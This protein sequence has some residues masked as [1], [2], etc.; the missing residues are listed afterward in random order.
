MVHEEVQKELLASIYERT[1]SLGYQLMVMNTFTDMYFDTED[2][3]NY[4]S[5]VGES[6]IFNLIN[7]DI[8][9]GLIVACETFKK[10][11]VLETLIATAKEHNTPIVAIDKYIEGA[12]NVNFSYEKAMEQ[13][14]RHIIEHHGCTRINFIAGIKGNSFSEER[15]NV[16]KAVLT[17]HNIPVEE[18]RIG[19]GEFWDMPTERVMDDFLNSTLPF[20]E[21]IVCSNDTM[22]MC[23]CRKLNEKGYKIPED[24]LVTGFD[25]II[26][27]RYHIPR[28]TTAK[29]DNFQAGKVAVDIL[30]DAFNGKTPS[31]SNTIYHKF[32]T[33]GSCGCNKTINEY[34]NV[35]IN[36]LYKQ[37]EQYKFYESDM[38]KMLT[39]MTNCDNIYDTI[40]ICNKNRYAYNLYADELWVC[41]CEEFLSLDSEINK[42]TNFPYKNMKVLYH[43]KY[44]NFM[45]ED[46]L[47]P[48]KGKEMVLNFDEVMHDTENRYLMFAPMNFQ[49]HAIGYIVISSTSANFNFD[50]HMLFS[51]NLSK[52]FSIIQS[53]LKLKNIVIKLEETNSKLEEMYVR[54]YLTGLL[55]RRGFYKNLTDKIEEVKDDPSKSFMVISID[56]NGLKYINDTFGHSDGDNAIKTVAKYMQSCAIK[57]EVCARFGGDEFIVASVIDTDSSYPKE[58]VERLKS[59]IE[60]YNQ[61]SGKPYKVGASCGVLVG[62][63]Q[64]ESEVDAMIKSADDIMYAEKRNSKY[65]RG[66]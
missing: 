56:L 55:N 17:E 32:I 39:T 36:R 20:P 51:T 60:G 38:Q 25:G 13:I 65:Q 57:D 23:C 11:D 35:A 14:M 8:I 43:Y 26:E 50:A 5:T 66:R 52:I 63:P 7:Y 58:Y 21:A 46:V 59:S 54:D 62:R 37:L 6:Q 33:A 9:D 34:T 45:T 64:S 61:I 31:V 15:L 44:G 40:E 49:D 41:I 24:I 22:A 28:L 3:Y 1:K 47:K 27:E 30:D 29:Q 12:Y 10:A 42:V 18:E 16:Y 48:F 53:N 4:S 19:Y 2:M